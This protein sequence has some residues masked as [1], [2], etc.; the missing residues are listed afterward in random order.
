MFEWLFC[1]QPTLAKINWR[2]Y[3]ISKTMLSTE[4]YI[5]FKKRLPF[6]IDII[7]NYPTINSFMDKYGPDLFT[8]KYIRHDEQQ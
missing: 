6:Q 5:K 8:F 2:L 3:I 7:L 4:V 1:C